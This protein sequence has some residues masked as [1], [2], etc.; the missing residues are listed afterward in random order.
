MASVLI[1]FVNKRNTLSQ[2]YVTQYDLELTR[3]D[4][5]PLERDE[6]KVLTKNK[7]RKKGLRKLLTSALKIPPTSMEIGFVTMASTGCIIHIVH[8]S[9]Q[10]QLDEYIKHKNDNGR[11]RLGIQDTGVNYTRAAVQLIE[12]QYSVHKNQVNAAINQHFEFKSGNRIKA[13][14][15]KSFGYNYLLSKKNIFLDP[16]LSAEMEDPMD[17]YWETCRV[18]E[19]VGTNIKKIWLQRYDAIDGN[20]DELIKQLLLEKNNECDEDMIDDWITMYKAMKL[21]VPKEDD[22]PKAND[23]NMGHQRYDSDAS[24]VLTAKKYVQKSVD[25]TEEEEKKNGNYVQQPS[26]SPEEE[27]KEVAQNDDA[28]EKEIDELLVEMQSILGRN[29]SAQTA[30]SRVSTKL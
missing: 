25:S 30:E 21:E 9:L 23:N 12:K 1:H 27:D 19:E 20:E 7:E 26:A 8:Y 24:M 5:K 16:M 2:S 13:E 4:K 28:K 14:Y 17:D 29:V 3:T 18:M 15:C 6:R 11:I 10:E 22:S